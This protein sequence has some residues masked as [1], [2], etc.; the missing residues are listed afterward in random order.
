VDRRQQGSS[1]WLRA[2]REQS[3]RLRE[4]GDAGRS[5]LARAFGRARR[6]EPTSA[7]LAE[8]PARAMGTPE[9]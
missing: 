6:I 5:T 3:A 4:A 2:S 1:A 7:P 9:R 8:E